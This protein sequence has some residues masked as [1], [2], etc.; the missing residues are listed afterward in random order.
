M[1]INAKHI[2]L[3]A[4]AL[5]VTAIAAQYTPH[6]PVSNGV[7]VAP[8]AAVS[9]PVTTAL[10]V[11]ASASPAPVG[12]TAPTAVAVAPGKPV[13]IAEQLTVLGA[14]TALTKAQADLAEQQQR[15]RKANADLGG[16]PI[17]PQSGT[18]SLKGPLPSTAP[19]YSAAAP[20]GHSVTRISS[21]DGHY[22]ADIVVDGRSAPSVQVGDVVNGA[23][24]VTGI[25]DDSVTLTYIKTGKSVTVSR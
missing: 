18:V 12:V 8:A 20:S 10:V 23:Y 16:G 2:L 14:Q 9:A 3:V 15:L 5:P 22:S 21:F 25:S 7:R 17:I 4:A 11:P 13:S 24:R 1:R 6:V 19:A